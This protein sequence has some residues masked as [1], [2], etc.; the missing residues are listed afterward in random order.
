MIEK[1]RDNDKRHGIAKRY[2]AAA[3]AAAKNLFGFNTDGLSVFHDLKVRLDL[4]EE[5]QGE[6]PKT[7]PA[8]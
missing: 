8:P 4:F 6:A 1:S 2:P 3:G 5:S 7:K